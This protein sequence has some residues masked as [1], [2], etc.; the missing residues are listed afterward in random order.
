MMIQ[1]KRL[2]EEFMKYVQISSPTKSEKDFADFLYKELE[3]LG[4][5]VH[6]DDTA[7]Q[8]GSNTG[9]LIAKL[10]GD[11]KGE[12]VIFSCHMDTVSPAIG[13]KPSLA[14]GVIRSDGTTILAADDKAGIAAIIEALR[15]ISE[16]NIPHG[17]IGL[18]FSVF[19]EGGL[20][21][22]K[23]LDYAQFGARHAFVLDSGGD[24][25]QII[26]QGPAQDKINFHVKGRAAHA[27]VAPEEGISA[28]SIAAEAISKMKLLRIDH[29]TTA[30]I[31]RIEGGSVTN[32][33]A[34]DVYVTSEARSLTDEKLEAQSAHMIACFEE[35]AAKF[36]GS[37]AVEHSR[38]YSSFKVDPSDEIVQRVSSAFASIGI[39][40]FTQATGGGS[41]TNV[42]NQKGIRAVN[43]GIGER[44]A[45][46]LEEHIFV[47]DLV[48]VSRLVLALIQEYH[49]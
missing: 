18:A 9:N 25:G 41:D 22:A 42:I 49:R 8:T 28:I 48:N 1:E 4:L 40:S 20:H 33:V 14:D 30:N 19:E 46:S 23:A 44:K 11:G 39:P 43:L 37:V 36:G 29:E 31:G 32:I 27:G 13:I 47:K 15:V 35:A 45:H 21:G 38:M 17:D 2:V 12:P 16:H 5:E 7:A 24:P 34:E 6:I 3:A 10:K 26:I